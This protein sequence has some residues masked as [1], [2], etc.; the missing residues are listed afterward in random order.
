MQFD[1]EETR[2]ILGRQ[3]DLVAIHDRSGFPRG[4][5]LEPLLVLKCVNLALYV[6][7]GNR[8]RIRYLRPLGGQPSRRSPGTQPVRAD[9]S[10]RSLGPGQLMGNSHCLR[11]FIPT[12]N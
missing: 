8:R 2:G 11:E 9:K 6:G 4:G 12:N 7:I 5:A 3:T 10:C 1:V